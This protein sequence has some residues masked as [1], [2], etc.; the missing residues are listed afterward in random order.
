MAYPPGMTAP[1]DLARAIETVPPATLP[2]PHRAVMLVISL[3]RGSLSC[4]CLRARAGLSTRRLY[5]VLSELEAA[6]WIRR[7]PQ[8]QDGRRAATK[9][10]IRT[11]GGPVVRVRRGSWPAAD[12]LT[13]KELQ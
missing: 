4:E 11:N 8:Y 6:R 13:T 2:A 3:A 5:R 7:V 1:Q 9:Y 12:A 10:E